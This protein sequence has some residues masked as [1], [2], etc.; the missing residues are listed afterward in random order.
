ME[1]ELI[2]PCGMYSI[3]ISPIIKSIF[4]KPSC[5][6]WY[7]THWKHIR[8]FWRCG[9]A[10]R[11][12]KSLVQELL[13]YLEQWLYLGT[14]VRTQYPLS[15]NGSFQFANLSISPKPQIS[16]PA[17]DIWLIPPNTSRLKWRGCSTHV[18]VA[19]F[20]LVFSDL[21]QDGQISLN[22]DDS[23]RCQ[24]ESLEFGQSTLMTYGAW[25][26]MHPNLQIHQLFHVLL[27][28]TKITPTK[29]AKIRVGWRPHPESI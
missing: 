6:S 11:N 22:N 28:S 29:T 20:L 23:E 12:D 5:D 7:N 14:K 25:K 13:R 9:H 19:L 18:T 26:Q 2:L 24:R 27:R 3:S 8:F 17:L 16:C 4:Q 21:S 1:H 10:L 15:W